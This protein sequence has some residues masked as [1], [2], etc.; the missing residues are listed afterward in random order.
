MAYLRFIFVEV[1]RMLTLFVGGMGQ[2]VELV[3]VG[4]PQERPNF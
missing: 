1:D 4:V 3:V 2:A